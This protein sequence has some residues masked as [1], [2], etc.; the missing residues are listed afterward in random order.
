MAHA[1]RLAAA[2]HC[3]ELS[4]IVAEQNLAAVALYR[5]LGYAAVARRPVVAVP[6]FGH[7]GDWVLMTRPTGAR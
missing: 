3:R 2:A 5:R 7:G 4:L 6:G 1:L